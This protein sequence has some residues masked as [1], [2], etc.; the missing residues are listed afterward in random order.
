MWWGLGVGAGVGDEGG[1]KRLQRARNC[2]RCEGVNRRVVEWCRLEAKPKIIWK[3]KLG[4]MRW[5]WGAP[6]ARGMGQKRLEGHA[7]AGSWGF[8]EGEEEG[9][10]G[11]WI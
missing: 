7:R 3:G 1:F 9:L 11:G 4:E 2:G 10:K 8:T 5:G 6:P